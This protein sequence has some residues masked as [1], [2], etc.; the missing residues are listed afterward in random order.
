MKVKFQDLFILASIAAA[1][2]AYT[3]SIKAETTQFD[4]HIHGLAELMI[5]IEDQM[6][7]IQLQSPA[8]NLV[9]FEHKAHTKNE[10]DAVRRTESILKSPYALFTFK[11]GQCSLTETSVDVSSIVGDDHTGVG[12]LEHETH[13][14]NHNEAYAH[15]Q[16]LCDNATDLSAVS[17]MMFKDFP[18]LKQTRVLWVT[19]SKQGAV[20]LDRDNNTAVFE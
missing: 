10:V 9:G 17:V 5:V 16:Y 19:K 8:M 4:A 18:G 12:E 2:I 13:D 6:V 11:G 14:E 3:G 20:T 7:D 1:T 15:Y